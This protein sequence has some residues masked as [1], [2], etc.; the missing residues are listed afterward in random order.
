MN[1]RGPVMSRVFLKPI[2]KVNKKRHG[3]Y[4]DFLGQRDL[5]KVFIGITF[6]KGKK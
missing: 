6:K 3:P 4:F 2:G 5:M 1:K